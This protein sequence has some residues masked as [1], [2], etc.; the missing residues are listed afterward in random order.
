MAVHISCF[1]SKFC[2]AANFADERIQPR[3]SCHETEIFQAFRRSN[4]KYRTEEALSD[5]D[6]RQYIRNWAK[7]YMYPTA[8][9]TA[10][11][12]FKKISLVERT[13]PFTGEQQGFAEARKAER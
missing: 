1:L 5:N 11:G 10:N 4:A 9:R 8:E 2:F 7:Q 13:D 6:L 12:Y 3:G